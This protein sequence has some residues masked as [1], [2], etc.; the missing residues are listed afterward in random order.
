MTAALSGLLP[1]S[2]RARVFPL[3]RE[4]AE[5]LELP[6]REEAGGLVIEFGSGEI[7]IKDADGGI[8]LMLKAM[9]EAR[10]Y[11]LQQVV[12]A[13][14]D[15]LGPEARV[16]WA[17]VNA[18]T[19]PPNF[20]LGR[21]ER[22]TRISPGF[23]RVRVTSPDLARFATGGLHFRLLLPPLDREPVWPRIGADGRTV[24]PEKADA[25]HRPVYT[26]RA[27]DPASGWLDFD[28]FLHDGSRTTDWSAAAT[29]GARIGMMGGT[30]REVP[31]TD[32]IALFGDETAMPAVIRLIE[33]LPPE[34]RGRA[35]VLTGDPADRQPVAVPEGVEFTWLTRGHTPGLVKELGDLALPAADRFIWFAAERAEAEAARCILRDRR[36]LGRSETSVTTYWSAIRDHA[37]A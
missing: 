14:L 36:G 30:G 33:A 3:F 9:T 27:I 8:A 23:R 11:M 4:L 29:P 34:T 20:T 25:L 26:V 15:P 16:R 35:L 7:G 2:A 22:I 1:D 21:V 6:R 18:G 12:F 31:A 32:W 10:L 5:Q 28:V 19:A 24:W 37:A 17:H 13:R